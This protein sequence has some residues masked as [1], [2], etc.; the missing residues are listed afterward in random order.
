MKVFYF[1]N[2]YSINDS[3][4][5]VFEPN[6]LTI[7]VGCNGYG[8]TSF[9]KG[10]E[11]HL[12]RRRVEYVSWSDSANGRTN[13]MNQFLWDNDIEAL[14]SMAFHSEGQAMV[15]SFGN[16]CLSKVGTKVR[17]MKN[18]KEL[19]VLVDQ[20]DSGLDTHMISDIKRAF[21]QV[22]IPDMNK[23]GVTAYV[24]LTANSY[25][26]VKDEYCFDPV[27]RHAIIFNNYDHYVD[28]INSM[29]ESKGGDKK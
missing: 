18:L 15:A 16:K 23:H 20:I 29:Y 26:L 17:H 13:G 28:Y 27:T 8:K 10:L 1:D 14:A 21:R 24:V 11:A 25:E 7:I 19:F 9:I 2:A 6:G 3:K 12:K 5:A 22:I 4:Y